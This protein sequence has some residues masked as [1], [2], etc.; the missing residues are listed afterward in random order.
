MDQFHFK[1]N[2]KGMIDLLSNHLYSTPHVFIRELIQNAVDA[3]TARN[4]IEPTHQGSIDVEIFSSTPPTLYIEDNGIGLTEDEVHQFLS[5]IGQTSKRGELESEDFIG[6]FG[7]G[8]LSCFIVSDEIVLLTRS[9]KDNTTIE[10]RGKPDGSYTIKKLDKEMAPGTRIY[11]Q[12]KPGY[13]QY[14]TTQ[15]V[16][17]MIQ[18]YGE[19]LPYPIFL[20][21]DQPIQ[22][23]AP[24]AP[25]EMSPE[26]ALKYAQENYQQKYL[27]AIPL[28]S[29]LG[30]AKGIAY[31]LPY[32]VRTNAKQT[33][34]VYVKQM[35]LSESVEKILPDWAF[36]VTSILNVNQLRLTASR[37]E[38]YDDPMLDQ[39]R[40]ELGDKIR[41]YLIKLVDTQPDLLERI[42]QIHYESIKSLAKEDD[43]LYS[44]FI[45]WLPFQTTLGNKKMKEIRNLSN[46]ILYTSN[47]D[48]YRQIQQV[49][50]S[51]SICVVNGAFVHNTELIRQLPKVFPE[52][53]I[54]EVNPLTFSQNFTDLTLAER[55]KTYHFIKLANVIL[56]RFHCNA[57]IKKFDP[58][59]LPALYTTN[60][61]ALFL[62]TAEHTQEE[63][64]DLFSSIIQQMTINHSPNTLASLCFNYRNPTIQKAIQS[65]N[66]KMVESVIEMLYVQALL[67]GHYPLKQR[68][69]ELLNQGLIRFMETGLEEGES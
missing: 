61:E 22:L 55:E 29:S 64:N 4:Q 11:L 30:D 53:T 38:F 6:R 24:K 50:K 2:L 23:N 15:K 51:Q 17:E 14:F 43:E 68:E 47:L 57:E 42:I 59:D 1:V 13:E 5:Q 20:H 34:R 12:S 62:R 69:F 21:K 65:K 36:F 26:E 60:E 9:I 25:W 33:H 45:D 40:K 41:D 18:H 63:S 8:L 32:P 31:I 48:E 39:V 7:V 66:K 67:L 52:L 46:E 35:L 10:W 19:F 3:I 28:S 56:Q 44:L 27:D 54:R 58:Q 49:A 16:K 37:E